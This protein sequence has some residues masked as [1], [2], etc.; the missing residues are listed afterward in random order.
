MKIL[1]IFVSAFIFL[2]CHNTEAQLTYTDYFPNA[3]FNAPVDIQSPKDES[4]RLFVVSQP[5]EIYFL[6]TSSPE[7][8]P[9]KFLDIKDKVLYGGEQGLLGLAFH[10]GFS[11]NGYFFVDYVAPNPRR[12]VIARF[13]VS[14]SD[15]NLADPESELVILE[16]KQP[17]SNHNGGQVLF[18]PDGYLYIGTGD[19]GSG[20]DPENRA[21]NRDSLLGK[22]LRIDVNNST[23]AESYTIPADNPFAGNSS[24]YREEIFAYGLRNPWR[25][26]FDSENGNLWVA[27]VGQNDY[28]EIDIVEKGGNYGWK[29]MEGFHC[30]NTA[31]CNQSGLQLPVFEYEH[32]QDG[33]Y[34]I[35]GGYVYRGSDVPS[36]FGKYIYADYVSGNIWALS[37]SGGEYTN[38]ILFKNAQNIT[39]FGTDE[40]NELYFSSFSDGKIHKFEDPAVDVKKKDSRP[41]TGFLI[42]YPN[43][44]NPVTTIK[45]SVAS[46]GAR[47]IV[48][49]QL[50]IFNL[51]GQ[52]VATLVDRLQKPGEYKAEFNADKLTSGIYLCR[53]S[54][55]G[56]RNTRSETIKLILLK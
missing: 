33:G 2:S 34:S 43:P 42:S 14:N 53:L 39:G 37:E 35:T 41:V 11:S 12:T 4:S 21:Q 51:L 28:E 45:Y 3:T 50:K 52:E 22:I 54:T 19:G 20:G 48:P 24:G 44:F 5:G 36:L 8:A 15:P 56:N 40:N 9:V 27:D 17:Y 16:I 25:F 31:G 30:Y 26:S 10:P 23:E 29:I 6:N 1:M 46:V 32:N 18:G 38:E 47:S 13:S 7:D 55:S 49:V